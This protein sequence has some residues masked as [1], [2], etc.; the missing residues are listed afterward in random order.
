MA[1]PA[2]WSI[3]P[4]LAWHPP[5]LLSTLLMLIYSSSL[6][7]WIPFI[8]VGHW[9][10]NKVSTGTSGWKWNQESK[11]E[12]VCAG[13][14]NIK[15]L[16]FHLGTRETE[17][18]PYTFFSV[19]YSHWSATEKWNIASCIQELLLLIFVTL[20]T[21]YFIKIAPRVLCGVQALCYAWSMFRGWW[22]GLLP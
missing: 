12:V 20:I 14:K 11:A 15:H 21:L 17:P 22:Q 7:C 16:T 3:F 5:T 6:Q 1:S 2:Q 19:Y 10:S 9:A 8:W 4:S 18:F 13:V